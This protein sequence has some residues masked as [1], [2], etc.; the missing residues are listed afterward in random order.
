MPWDP[1]SP[2]AVTEAAQYLAAVMDEVARRDAA[3]E[4]GAAR[5]SPRGAV[6]RA[7]DLGA[8]GPNDPA[9]G[10]LP[11]AYLAEDG[12]WTF[13]GFEYELPLPPFGTSWEAGL[14]MGQYVAVPLVGRPRLGA[15]QPPGTQGS[16]TPPAGHALPSPS[17]LSSGRCT[18][19]P[20]PH[21]GCGTTA[22]RRPRLLEPAG[23]S[24][25]PAAAPR[26]YP[27]HLAALLDPDGLPGD[28]GCTPQAF[29]WVLHNRT[30]MHHDALREQ[31]VDFEDWLDR[32]SIFFEADPGLR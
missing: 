30:R 26:S 15:P 24:Q 10:P 17:G 9:D 5:V 14:V 7:S 18:P 32:M 28:P 25:A 1:P 16:A 20:A 8:H 19:G 31:M 12:R 29:F 22:P 27:A 4:D 13:E 6:P 11:G 23:P 2:A 21:A 3:A